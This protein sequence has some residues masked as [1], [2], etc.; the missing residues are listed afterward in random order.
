M[1]SNDRCGSWAAVGELLRWV[2]SCP[3]TGLCRTC[4]L[5]PAGA[6]SSVER[7]DRRHPPQAQRLTFL[8]LRILSPGTPAAVFRE[9]GPPFGVLQ[10]RCFL[11]SVLQRVR[12]YQTI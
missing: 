8:R 2:R 6:A 10:H 7:T 5:V 9:P 12:S 3:R 4:S 11:L 1:L